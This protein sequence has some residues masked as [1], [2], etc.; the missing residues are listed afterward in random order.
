M[1]TLKE[2][3]DTMVKTIGTQLGKLLVQEM[4]D[5]P[6]IVELRRERCRGSDT[7]KPCSFY[8]PNTDQC[9][10]CQCFIETKSMSKTNY[11]KQGKLEITHC[12]MGWWDDAEIAAK[13]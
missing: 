7:R 4:I 13:V 12:P 2:F 8:K 1:K 5:D 3:A 10:V 9:Q 11:N 6:E